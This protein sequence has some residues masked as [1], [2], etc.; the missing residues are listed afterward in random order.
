MGNQL[1]SLAPS[2]ILSVDH[3]LSDLP[4]YHYEKRGGLTVVKVFALPDAQLPMKF[5]QDKVHETRGK[6]NGCASLLPFQRTM[7]SD[8]AAF[9]IRQYMKYTLYDRISTRPFLSDIEKKWIAFQLL[10]AVKQMHSRNIQHGDIK[11]EN[12]MVTS[13]NWVMLTDFA[14]YKPVY[15]P[16]DNPAD[17]SYFFDTS[18]RRSCYIACERFLDSTLFARLAEN[19]QSAGTEAASKANTVTETMDYNKLTAAMDIFSVGCVLA[20]LFTEGHQLFDLSQLLAYRQGECLPEDVLSKIDDRS[21]QELILHMIQKDPMKRYSAEEYLNKWR[22]HS[23]PDVF[24][25]FLYYYMESYGQRPFLTSDEKIAKLKEDMNRIIKELTSTDNYINEFLV[26]ILPLLT[27]CIRDL[28]VELLTDSQPR[29]K[30]A[31]IR[32]L[33]K[34]LS[35]VKYVPKSDVNIF[36]EYI[37]H[38]L[39]TNDK[40]VFVRVAYA[41]NIA[42]LAETALRFLEVSHMKQYS[43]ESIFVKDSTLNF[44]TSYDIELQ[45]LQDLIQKKTVLLLSDT[46]NVVKRAIL[47]NGISKLCL[48]FG[49]QKASDVLLS[50][51]ITFLNDKSDWQMRGTFYDSIIGVAGYVGWQSLSMLRPL[52]QQGLSDPEEFVICKALEALTDVVNLRLLDGNVVDDVTKEVI[53]FLYHPMFRKLVSLGFKVEDEEKLLCMKEILLRIHHAKSSMDTSHTSEYGSPEHLELIALTKTKSRSLNLSPAVEISNEDSKKSSRR[54]SSADVGNSNTMN[55]E[56]KHMFGSTQKIDH[57]P[58]KKNS[59]KSLLSNLPSEQIKSSS[60]RKGSI[61]EKQSQLRSAKNSTSSLAADR[62]LQKYGSKKGLKAKQVGIVDW[63]KVPTPAGWKPKGELIAHI[64]EHRGAIT[65]IATSEDSKLFASGS[66]DGTVK[67]WE[68]KRMEG[69]TTMLK[70]NVTYAF[71]GSRVTSVEFCQQSS[72]LACATDNGVL[73]IVRLGEGST[74]P[75]VTNTITLDPKEGSIIDL[76][77]FDSGS[78]AV[79][80]Y[81]TTHGC[82]CGWDSR[83]PH[84]MAWKLQNDLKNGACVKCLTPNP[85]EQSWVVSSMQGN[86]EVSMWDVETGARRKML[87]ASS[88][89][90]MSTTQSSPESVLAVYPGPPDDRFILTAGTDRR[91]RYWDTESCGSSYVV[92]G[93][94]TETTDSSEFQYRSR[95]IDGTE[96]IIEKEIKRKENTQEDAPR[97]GPEAPFIGHHD[98]INQLTVVKGL[99]GLMISGAQDGVIKVWV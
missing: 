90:P 77:Y 82:I 60:D 19:S 37:L 3:Y 38:S 39:A 94:A 9:L 54:K 13:W 32:T 8:R 15:L 17:F 83:M 91:I 12:V 97:R 4:Q 89:P 33:T 18:R 25:D 96:V 78:Q 2:Q 35:N 85:K 58:S 1:S 55:A 74:Q 20:E 22:G 92:V 71:Q 80:S 49:R 86:N 88:A 75:T 68:A 76:Q 24:Y 44:Q 61:S 59:S 66:S 48:F 27:S 42:K 16:E 87:W 30:A 6:L 50:H 28:Q 64:R 95:A 65:K 69:R 29:A 51:M 73:R 72:A 36:L 41:E 43:D 53:P 34:C 11:T 26:L 57:L 47:E 7:I 81:V 99:Q 70:A 56:W 40:D 79:L 5:F 98:T 14:C 84:R 67:L 63:E 45:A 31:A 21:I 52:L 23:F 46:E 62:G 93:S 10:T